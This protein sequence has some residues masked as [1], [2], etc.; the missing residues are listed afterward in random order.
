MRVRQRV[1][2]AHANVLK[3]IP[4]GGRQM[5][6]HGGQVSGP[7]SGGSI[8]VGYTTTR[9]DRKRPEAKQ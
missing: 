5:P 4:R 9:D 3:C 8:M 2:L 1:T 7:A 6:F